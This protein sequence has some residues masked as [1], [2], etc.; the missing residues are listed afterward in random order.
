MKDLIR[1]IVFLLA[2]YRLSRL[3][4][5][6]EIADGPRNWVY[7]HTKPGGKIHYMLGC[8][9]CTS[10]WVAIPLAILYI[11]APD[12]MMVAGLPLAG[13]AVTGFL[14]QKVG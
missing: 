6:D 4:I 9:W 13:S 7:D 3:I 14:D 5:Q 10:F 11:R 12:G 2:V 1:F 8:Y